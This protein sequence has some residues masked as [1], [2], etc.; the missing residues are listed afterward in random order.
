MNERTLRESIALRTVYEQRACPPDD[1][2]LQ[3]SSEEMAAHVG[4]CR[5]C[6]ERLEMNEGEYSA[7]T[8]LAEKLVSSFAT[9][10]Q[11]GAPSPGEIWSTDSA[12]LGGWGSYDRYYTAPPVLI[13][14]LQDRDRTVRVAQ[15]CGEELLKGE[16]GTDVWL[17]DDIGFAESW[18]VY[19]VHR[20][21]LKARL[22]EGA[23]DL[24]SK[25]LDVARSKVQ[26]VLR[27]LVAQFREL[28][29]EVGASVAI[30]ALK[31]VMAE[32]E[33][34][35][36]WLATLVGGVD[37]V[38][39]RA[40][41]AVGGW[42]LPERVSS[43]LDLLSG[44]QPQLVP[45]LAAAR[46]QE[47]TKLINLVSAREDGLLVGTATAAITAARDTEEGSFFIRCRLDQKQGVT[48][49]LVARLELGDLVREVPPVTIKAG[50]K[51]FT[52]TFPEVPVEVC[53]TE[54]VMYNVKM[55]L[56][57]T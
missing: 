35:N 46:P 26:G 33:T 39:E 16:D 30:K 22:T 50:A 43:V 48:F 53:K 13:L 4:Y 5:Y 51:A 7:W 44:A 41:K 36:G 10:Q 14:Q 28:E 34:V 9:V 20:D 17:G 47:E 57:R 55:I 27:P 52:L 54:T 19:S 23:P 38:R 40:S 21:H 31:L 25:V 24:A 56:V 1:L 42:R 29:V 11:K 32:V 8:H 15:V 6:Q 49:H 37:Q 18:N 12:T 2:L 3:A 45:G